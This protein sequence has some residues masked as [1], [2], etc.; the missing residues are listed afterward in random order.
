MMNLQTVRFA[1]PASVAESGGGPR[2]HAQK[3]L[4]FFGELREASPEEKQQYF[5]KAQNKKKILIKTHWY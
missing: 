1:A 2:I 5:C 3:I 4:F